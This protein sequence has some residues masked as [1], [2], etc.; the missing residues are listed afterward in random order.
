MSE[1]PLSEKS[2]GQLHTPSGLAYDRIT[3]NS[4]L[5]GEVTMDDLR[6]TP[7]ALRMQAEIAAAEGR[8]QLAENLLRAAEL[9]KVPAETILQVYE[10]LRP[11]RAP[12]SRLL[13]L[14]GR[15]E[16]EFCAPL[17]ARLLREAAGAA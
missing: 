12:R 8:K 15:M 6:V 17:C 2:S 13:E 14:A 16:Q 3:L 1:Y 7:E 11:G 10:A 5:T 9:A 4:V